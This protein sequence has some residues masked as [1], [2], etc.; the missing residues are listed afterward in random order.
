[1]L[2]VGGSRYGWGVQPW[3]SSFPG[4]SPMF[5]QPDSW[6]GSSPQYPKPETI[7]PKQALHLRVFAGLQQRA[8]TTSPKMSLRS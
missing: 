1:M 4:C 7:Q 3:Q 2:V 5:G 6:L 8:R